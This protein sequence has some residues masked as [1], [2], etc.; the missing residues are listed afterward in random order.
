[1]TLSLIEVYLLLEYQKAMKQMT[2]KPIF[3]YFQFFVTPAPHLM[4]D[5]A[6]KC[7][8]VFQPAISGTRDAECAASGPEGEK[9]QKLFAKS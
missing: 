4:R 6:G 9:I 7:E 8:N 3:D 1:L 2:A 5:Y